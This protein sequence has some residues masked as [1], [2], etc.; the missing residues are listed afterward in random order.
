MDHRSLDLLF[1]GILA[2][3][4]GGV[5]VAISPR[6]GAA[7]ASIGYGLAAFILKGSTYR[8]GKALCF[9]LAITAL[10]SAALIAYE[11]KAPLAVQ[12]LV[13]WAGKRHLIFASF[14]VVPW[15]LA[16][17]KLVLGLVV[18]ALVMRARRRD[19][20]S[21]G[22]RRIAPASRL[23]SLTLFRCVCAG[24]LLVLCHRGDR[25]RFRPVERAGKRRSRP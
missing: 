2:G 4:A 16:A 24:G 13:L 12:H 6:F 25:L 1:A 8:L 9:G 22:V 7:L 17:L 19:P 20:R 23:A 3:L 18:H 21:G 15:A 11:V 10:L 14:A 5:L